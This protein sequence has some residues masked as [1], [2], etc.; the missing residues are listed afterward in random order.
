MHHENRF[1]GVPPTYDASRVNTCVPSRTLSERK[2]RKL[3]IVLSKSPPRTLGTSESTTV[4]TRLLASDLGCRLVQTV[5]K[6][7]HIG[8][9]FRACLLRHVQERRHKC[10]SSQTHHKELSTHW[11]ICVAGVLQ[12]TRGYMENPQ[13][14]LSHS[15][16]NKDSKISMGDPK[17]CS[18]C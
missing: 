16:F 17:T 3:T 1:H 7:Q 18:T 10:H 13:K 9:E 11:G 15:H 8:R 12:P 2:T 6:H 5:S 4:K 14:V